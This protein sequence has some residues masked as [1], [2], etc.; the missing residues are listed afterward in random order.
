MNKR[1]LIV[2]AVLV[3]MA[4][5]RGVLV[6]RGPELTAAEKASADPRPSNAPSQRPAFAAQTDAPLRRSG[7][8]FNVVTVARGLESPWGL[9]F[10]PDGR[11]LVTE[12]PGRLRIVAPD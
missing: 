7:V 11:M 6:M 10:L 1:L 3:A 2:L 5:I 4:A 9:A 8:A 12:R